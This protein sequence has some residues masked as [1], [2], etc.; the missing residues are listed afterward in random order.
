MNVDIIKKK[1][2]KM[3]CTCEKDGKSKWNDE[4]GLRTCAL[5]MRKGR[6]RVGS[7]W[8]RKERI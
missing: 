7:G 2:K 5:H 6:G 1:K 8:D 4:L 3:E